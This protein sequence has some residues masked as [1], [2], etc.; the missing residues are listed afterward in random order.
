MLLTRR[1]LIAN[2]GTKKRQ[3]SMITLTSTWLLKDGCPQE[4]YSELQTLAENVEHREPGTRTYLVHLAA[5][6]PL[7]SNGYPV[8]PEPGMIPLDQQQAIVFIETY[9]D[10]TALS[11]HINGKTFTSFLEGNRKY[12]LPGT[13]GGTS[14]RMNTDFLLKICGFVR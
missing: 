6:N 9:K 13:P 1:F 8:E 4:L 7:D 11:H 10:A 14:C 12:F 3:L 5:K 2:V